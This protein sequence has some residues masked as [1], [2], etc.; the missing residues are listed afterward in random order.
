MALIQTV[1]LAVVVYVAAL[2]SGFHEVKEGYV[3]LYKTLGVLQPELSEPGFHLRIPFYE[4]FIEMKVS[5]QTDVVTNIPCGTSNG[6][7]VYFDKVEVVNKLRK[8][9]AFETVRNYTE[10]YEKF[11]ITDKLHHEIN[12]FCS[13][14]SLQEIYIDIFDQLDEELI[15]SLGKDLQKWAPGIELLSIRVTKPNIPDRIKRNF[16]DMEK[17]KI[18]FF[19]AA[20]KEKVRLEEELTKQKQ[21]VIK[22]ESNLEVKKIDLRKMIDKKQNDLRMGVIEGEMI[23]DRAKTH[24]ETEFMA[25]TEEADSYPILFTD[26]YMSFLATDALTS[27]ATFLLGTQIPNIQLT[28]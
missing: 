19:I 21:Q 10:D 22:A 15:D 28:Q 18:D 14:H 12:Q 17:L 20:E 25:A 6:T 1:L 4:E 8:E 2:L 3:G 5:I 9:F 27:N 11:W 7:L 16:E 23:F 24:I 26:Q 13:K